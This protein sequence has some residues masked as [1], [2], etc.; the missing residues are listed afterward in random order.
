MG[1]KIQTDQFLGKLVKPFFD[2]LFF[3]PEVIEQLL[4]SGYGIWINGWEDSPA[5]P[6]TWDSDMLP[7]HHG[8]L[9]TQGPFPH[10]CS[11][12]LKGG[13]IIN[14]FC[15]SVTTSLVHL[16][17]VPHP[18]LQQYSELLRATHDQCKAKVRRQ[19]Y[20]LCDGVPK[21]RRVSNS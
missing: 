20:P 10:R 3:T 19:E 7:L 9:R 2:A 12:F 18:G 13:G 6:H 14:R 16:T 15:H 17:L 8:G 4:N 5:H 11:D 21:G 1:D